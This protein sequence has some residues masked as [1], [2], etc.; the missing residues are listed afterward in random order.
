MSSFT[1][2]PQNQYHLISNW[3]SL[4]TLKVCSPENTYHCTHFQ[5]Q[6]QEY[7][8]FSNDCV[9]QARSCFV[10]EWKTVGEQNILGVQYLKK[11]IQNLKSQYF[12]RFILDLHLLTSHISKN[13]L[14][15][16]LACASSPW[17][18]CQ[19]SAIK[20]MRNIEIQKAIFKLFLSGNRDLLFVIAYEYLRNT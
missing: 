12:R 9:A 7:F 20:F 18:R 15:R 11:V 10:G 2:G 14:Q 1:H 5:V 16:D 4:D 17:Q 8:P 6:S 19:S 13:C 3:P